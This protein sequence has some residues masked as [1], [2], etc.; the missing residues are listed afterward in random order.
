MIKTL[1]IDCPT[2]LAGDMLLAGFLDMKVPKNVI[3]G[4]LVS[5]G[6]EKAFELRVQEGQ[7]FGLRGLR[8]FV[9]GLE[10]EPPHRGWREIHSLINN[11]DLISGSLKKKV[12]DVFKALADAEALVHGK[13]VEEVHFHEIGSIDALVDVVG[14]CAAIEH[15]EPREII[16]GIPP[17]GRG[18]V[19]TAHGILPLPAPAV[20]ELARVNE[21]TLR[22]CETFPPGELTT[23][24]GLALMA[25]LAHKFGEPPSFCISKIGIGLGARSLDRPNLLRICELDT[26]TNNSSN[27]LSDGLMWQQIVIQEAWIDDASPEDVSAL[28]E[29]LRGS[30][31]LEVAC[32]QIQV[33]KGR[34]GVC[35]SALVLPNDAGELRMIWFSYGSTLGL[36]ERTDWRWVLPRRL[37]LCHTKIGQIRAKQALRPDG[38]YTC[39]PEYED[40]LR[41]SKESGTSLEELRRQVALS[42]EDFSPEEDW[43]W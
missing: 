31:A 28:A 40:L 16:C 43:S 14:V 33:K 19:F 37:G 30:G 24:T 25:V 8:A 15:L 21:I 11:A 32:Q 13:R 20:L 12:L 29:K 35:V 1:F 39:K 36:R 34:I 27:E 23:P 41:L 7:S 5:L 2:G 10:E 42:S 3:E 6:L 17:A 18:T 26:T 4:P 22:G 38:R 9:D